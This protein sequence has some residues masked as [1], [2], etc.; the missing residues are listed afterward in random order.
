MQKQAENA[1]GATGSSSFPE[2]RTAKHKINYRIGVSG[3][4]GSFSEEAAAQYCREK[5]IY[6]VE[7]KYLVFVEKVLE[8]LENGDIDFG[9]FA[10]EN[11]IGGIV[12]E[13]LPALG[14]HRWNHIQTLE[15][16]VNHMLLGRS[17]MRKEGTRFVIT[18]KQAYR[19]CRLH[20]ERS[21][22][23]A[24][25]REEIDTATAARLLSEGKYPEGTAVIAPRGCAKLYGL[26]ILEEGI[27]DDRYNYTT[28]IVATPYKPS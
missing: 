1:T 23:D 12:M 19:Q 21:F 27:Q 8:A 24:E 7:I 14:R 5:G 4:Q 18:Q 13:Y 9:I 11:R 22:P 25:V 17:G 3:A 28:F 20:I 10:I 6:G 2:Y 16:Q 26:Q 15:V